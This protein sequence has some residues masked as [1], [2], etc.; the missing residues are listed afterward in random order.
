[1]KIRM[2]VHFRLYNAFLLI[3]LH[4]DGIMHGRR[5]ER[6]SKASGL[7]GEKGQIKLLFMIL[8]HSLRS[9]CVRGEGKQARARE[10]NFRVFFFFFL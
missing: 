7:G 3:Y 8:L 4:C 2:D 1:M 5:K 10:R 9:I 6:A